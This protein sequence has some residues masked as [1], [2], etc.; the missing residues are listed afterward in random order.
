MQILNML[1]D[2]KIT[3]E[4]AERLLAA[5]DAQPAPGASG[6]TKPARWLRVRV[7]EQGRQI[8]NVNVPM[9]VVDVAVN[10]G[11]KFVPHDQLQDIDVAALMQAIKQG[12]MG[13]IVEIDDG[14]T[15]VEVVVE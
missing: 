11:L 6:A 3:A 14:D 15:K 9:A 4:E 2:G 8:V 7:Q 12:A 10:M 5:L 1:Q 13:K